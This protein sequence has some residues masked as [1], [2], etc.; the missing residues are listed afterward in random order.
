MSK[1]SKIDLIFGNT[2]RGKVLRVF[3]MNSDIIFSKDEISKK[4][5][6]S[7]DLVERETRFIEKIGV[8]KKRKTKNKNGRLVSGWTMNKDYR[9][10]EALRNFLIATTDYER[11]GILKYIQNVCKPKLLVASQN[12]LNKENESV[13]VLIVADRFD[14]TRLSKAMGNMESN[15]GREITYVAMTPEDFTYRMGMGDKLLRDIF[16]FEYKIITDKLGFS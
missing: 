4:I 7:K 1:D 13:D 3:V 2:S 14:E 9:Y 10:F 16:D 8:I 6:M 15:F 12:I 11:D 5:K